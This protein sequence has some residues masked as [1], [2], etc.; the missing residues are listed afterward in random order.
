MCFYNDDYDWYAEVQ[1]VETHVAKEI[2]A[3]QECGQEIAVGES[4]RYIYQQEHEE[5]QRCE[6][7]QLDPDDDPCEQHDYGETYHYRCCNQCQRILEIIQL[8]EI[9]E[10]CPPHAQQ[11]G[12]GELSE[13]FSEHQ[14]REQYAQR[15]LTLFPDLSGHVLLA[16]FLA[17]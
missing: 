13:V 9:E 16:P 6:W 1:T 4:Y 3:C 12:L 11:P 17:K 14:S 7:E 10:G 2:F 5:C 8:I 15:V